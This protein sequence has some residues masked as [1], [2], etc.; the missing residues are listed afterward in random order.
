MA[1]LRAVRVAAAV[2]VTVFVGMIVWSSLEMNLWAGLKAST[3]SR[4]GVLTL[5]DVYTGLLVFGAFIAWR[6]RSGWR[7]GLWLVAL[8]TLGNLA[9]LAYVFWASRRASAVGDLFRPVR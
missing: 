9:T 1:E 6:E 7:I 5:V 4:W 3:D 8:L 2:G